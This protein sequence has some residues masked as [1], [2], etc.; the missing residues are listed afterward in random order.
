[1]IG[2]THT[3]IY[4]YNGNMN[5][6]IYIS[7]ISIYI[8]IYIEFCLSRW[9]Q[10]SLR[11]CREAM[12][13]SGECMGVP[14]NGQFAWKVIVLWQVHLDKFNIAQCAP[15]HTYMYI[16]IYIYIYIYKHIWYKGHIFSLTF[17][18]SKGLEG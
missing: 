1:M 2:T 7:Y 8:Y 4:I 15:V 6:Y 13:H 3:A 12:G 14:P 18:S 5:V 17:L 16:Y 10:C 11:P 9:L